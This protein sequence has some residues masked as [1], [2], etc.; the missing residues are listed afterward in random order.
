[1]FNNNR[2]IAE[3]YMSRALELA[4]KGMGRTLPNPM[5]GAV[6][7][8]NGRVIGEGFH[9]YFGGL[10]AERNALAAV[11]E[12]PAGADMYV[13]LEPCDHHGKTPPCTEAIIESGIKRV[14]IGSD[15][16][17]PKVSGKGT[18]HLREAGI[19]VVT[20]VLKDKCEELN[21]IFL[22]YIQTGLPYVCM[23]YAMTADGKI[24]AKT[25]DS[26]WISSDESRTLVQEMRNEY[27]AIMAGIGTVLKDDPL[28]TCR[29]EDGVSPVRIICDS[30]LR[31]PL[32]SRIVKTARQ[33]P[34]FAVCALPDLPDGVLVKASVKCNDTGRFGKC[35]TLE[36]GEQILF[37]GDVPDKIKELA[38]YGVGIINVCCEIPEGIVS[39]EGS[40]YAKSV[41]TDLKELIRILG[42]CGIAGI[43]LEGGGELNYSA[44][45]AGIVNEVNV[46][47]GA[48][49]VGGEAKT[50]VRGEGIERMADAFPLK[51]KGCRRVGDDVLVQYTLR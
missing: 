7:V 34:T 46:F 28:L 25:G 2:E 50:P 9:E 42:D 48:K 27:P 36:G 31:I 39:F 41:R 8:K 1:M 37:E 19:E 47:L 45:E 5:V 49:L 15:D 35:V 18:A 12:S 13:T 4:K 24:A 23:K 17:N 6:I 22:R 32:D 30:S 40:G 26:K 38:G 21:K 44:L 51:L 11:T 3:L 16:P 10:H 14:F 29:L 33:T 43:L 20:G